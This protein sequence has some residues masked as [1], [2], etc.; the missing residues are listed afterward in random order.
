MSLGFK[1]LSRGG[2]L[3]ESTVLDTRG[4]SWLAR[5]CALQA[6]KHEQPQGG[7]YGCR[8]LLLTFGLMSWRALGSEGLVVWVVKDGT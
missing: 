2:T 5:R 1:V 4:G 3:C 8:L 7:P 6:G